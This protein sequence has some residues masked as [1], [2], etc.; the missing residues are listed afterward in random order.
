MI[1]YH[2]HTPMNVKGASR[3]EYSLES[4]AT[5]GS[6]IEMTSV[7]RKKNFR[8]LKGFSLFENSDI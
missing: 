2:I 8:Q 4:A 3:I 7:S 5:I 1:P 6:P